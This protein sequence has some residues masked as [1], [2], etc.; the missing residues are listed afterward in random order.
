MFE[1]M[2]TEDPSKL[3]LSDAMH[4][5]AAPAYVIDRDGRFRWLNRAYVELLG[6][7]RG[8]PFIERVAPE[9]R[10]LARTN[11]AKKLSGKTTGI[12]DLAVFDRSG[13]R[14][15][16]R[17]TSAPLRNGTGVLGVFGIAIPLA[18]ISALERSMLADLTPRQQEV[19]RLL[20][21]GL[22]TEVI[23][24]RLGI[25]DETARNHIRALLRTMGAHSRL[26][27]VLMGQRLGI[28]GPHVTRVGHD[29]SSGPGD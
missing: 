26:G 10:Q 11:F 22:D 8:R 12:F 9:H 27:A 4:A 29:G 28:V 24:R 17:I 6:D 13:G 2:L 5:L 16:L 20:A 19:L 21:E 7:L 23:A 1:T 25:A 14:V 3:D 15:T 18:H